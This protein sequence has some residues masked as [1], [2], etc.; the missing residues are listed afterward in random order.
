MGKADYK[1]CKMLS[2]L[3]THLNI[4]NC[5]HLFPKVRSHIY[6][7]GSELLGEIIFLKHILLVTINL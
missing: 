6:M 5:N 4:L 3:S 7:V 2:H 1:L